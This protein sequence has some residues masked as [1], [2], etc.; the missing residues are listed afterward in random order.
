LGTG[1]PPVALDARG[2]PSGEVEISGSASSQFLTALLMASPLCENEQGI[3]IKIK[4]ELVSLP[5]VSMTAKLLER[6]GIKVESDES[7]EDIF[8]PGKQMY[9]SPGTAYVEGT[10]VD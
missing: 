1:C 2:I 5:Y 10:Y 9:K 4:D 3:R 7:Y 8:V 6:F